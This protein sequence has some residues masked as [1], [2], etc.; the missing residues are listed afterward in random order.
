ML[1]T[2]TKFVWQWME[3]LF[4]LINQPTRIVRISTLAKGAFTATEKT[5]MGYFSWK[6]VITNVDSDGLMS[7]I[8][9]VPQITRYHFEDH[10]II[11]KNAFGKTNTMVIPI[12][13]TF[14]TV[15]QDAYNFY[16]SQLRF[17]IKR[18]FDMFLHWF[19]I[20]QS[21]LSTYIKKVHTIVICL[22]HLHSYYINHCGR[23][24]N[25]PLEEDER[26]IR[27]W[28]WHA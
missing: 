4:G 5:N 14:L 23:I 12:T 17:T 25:S 8:Q 18:A 9:A 15:Y 24:C 22:M 28:E 20:L 2:L 3:L 11:N 19:G 6:D 13:S 10:T 26:R 7:G 21:P 16:L 1:L 27:Y